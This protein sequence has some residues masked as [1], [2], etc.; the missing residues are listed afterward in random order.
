MERLD[1]DT[2][3]ADGR[4]ALLADPA[5]RRALAACI[6]RQGLIDQVLSGLSPVPGSYLP[7]DHPLAA[8]GSGGPAYDPAAGQQE[9]ESSGWIDSDGSAPWREAW[10]GE[11]APRS[12][13]F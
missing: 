1:F 5:I 13:S 12:T 2:A 8:A 3:P 4:A 11:T 9:L 7:A 6:D 10:P